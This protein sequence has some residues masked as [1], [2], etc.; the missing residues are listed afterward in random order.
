MADI[1]AALSR[2][3]ARPEYL[4]ALVLG[5]FHAWLMHGAAVGDFFNSYPFISDD[6][7]DWIAQGVAFNERLAGI[8]VSP[9]PVLRS[10]VFVLISALDDALGASG[11]V[12]VLANGAAVALTVASLGWLGRRLGYG[13]P[14]LCAVLLAFYFSTLGFWR[15]WILSDTICVALMTASFCLAIAHLLEPNRRLIYP[16]M[17]FAVAAGLTQTY[18]VIAFCGVVFIAIAGR[19]LTGGRIGR[20]LPATLV[21]ALALTFGLKA[22]W[23]A[24]IP[25]GMEPAQFEMLKLSTD[26]TGYYLNVWITAFGVFVPLVVAALVMRLRR[27]LWPRLYEAGLVATLLGFVGLSYF[28]QWPE[29]RF[30]FIYLSVFFAV[31]LMVC[32]PP[33]GAV[34]Q[35]STVERKLVW[36][37]AASA[38]IGLLVVPADYWSPKVM[39]TRIDWNRAWVGEALLTPPADRFEL[40]RRCPTI[41]DLCPAAAAPAQASPYRQQMFDQYKRR[42]ANDPR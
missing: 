3:A 15:L 40:A 4:L 14:A 42:T 35:G 12:I 20:A 8:D 26:M 13:A 23:A 22:A 19:L 18:G 36:T 21:A 30:T 9:W 16:A 38:L 24:M 33:V 10:P 39:G 34:A 29:S 7:F 37:C 41:E 32:R 27:R 28:Y 6:G 11:G 5:L 2:R 17:A 25:H 31:L 1:A